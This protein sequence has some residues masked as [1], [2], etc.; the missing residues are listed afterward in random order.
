MIGMVVDLVAPSLPAIAQGL[1]VSNSLAKN[2][3]SIYMLGYALG[4]FFLG[5]LTDAYGRQKLLRVSLLGFVIVSLLPAV[6]PDIRVLLLARFLQGL[7]IGGAA[8]IARAIFSDVLPPEKL[9]RMGVLIGTMWGLGPV[10]GPVIGGY[11][12]F[13]FGWQAGFW[14]FSILSC[15]LL[16]SIFITV[17]ETHFNRHPLNIKTISK[18]LKEIFTHRLFMALVILMG[19]AYSLIIVFNTL[20]PFLIQTRLN[21]SSIF[22]GHLALVLGLIFLS[23]TMICRYLLKNYETEQ[24]LRII[25]NLFL[26]LAAV[27][28]VLSFSYGQSI[29][30][31]GI[32]SGLMFFACGFIFPMSMGKGISLFRHIAGTASATMY[33][34][35]I[36]ITSLS[37][38]L[39]SFLAIHSAV[40]LMLIYFSLLLIA[41]V[42]YWWMIYNCKTAEV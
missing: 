8:L 5:F 32:G 25:I 40:P 18:N 29:I 34:I 6:F 2:I 11:L 14:F 38:F 23:A 13:Y 26:I 37:S 16:I 33:L 12:Q 30:L 28:F 15:L 39:V 7:T 10:I 4:N 24:L 1:Q 41:A 3:I 20:G 36:L 19:I 22:F 42:I 9:V 31:I 27:F 35:N 21:Y 17:P